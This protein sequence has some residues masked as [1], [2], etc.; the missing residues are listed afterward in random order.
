MND[1][2]AEPPLHDKTGQGSPAGDGGQ[3]A[4]LS[5]WVWGFGLVA[6]VGVLWYVFG[7]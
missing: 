5:P 3:G 7:R 2:Q 6:V 4:G 1:P